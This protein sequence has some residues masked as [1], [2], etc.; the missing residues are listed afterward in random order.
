MGL[1]SPESCRYLL[2]LLHNQKLQIFC[3]KHYEHYLMI[4][5]HYV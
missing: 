1:S 5:T 3:N 2:N 4:S